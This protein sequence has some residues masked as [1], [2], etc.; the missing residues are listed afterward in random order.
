MTRTGDRNPGLTIE[1]ATI[2]EVKDGPLVAGPGY[3]AATVVVATVRMAVTA[4]A[5]VVVVTVT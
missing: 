5:T 3:V 2:H 1:I 4:V